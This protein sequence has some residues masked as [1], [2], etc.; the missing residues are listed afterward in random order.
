MSCWFTTSQNQELINS[1]LQGNTF[2]LL[3]TKH[4]NCFPR[5]N[6]YCC[7]IRLGFLN[8]ILFSGLVF[9]YLSVIFVHPHMGFVYKN[10]FINFSDKQGVSIDYFGIFKNQNVWLP[11]I[12]S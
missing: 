12:H 4:L 3:S 8:C 1:S 11:D 6:T 2:D 7:V 9:V 10:L 5:L